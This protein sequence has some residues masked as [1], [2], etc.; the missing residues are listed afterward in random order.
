MR[1]L[2]TRGREDALRTADKLTN[3]GHQII[4]SPV[5]DICPTGAAWPQGLADAVVA[6]SGAA[7]D[8]A[9][10]PADYPLPEARRLMRLFV[11]GT[12]TAEAARRGGFTGETVVASD[13]KELATK[14]TSLLTPQMRLIYLAGHDRKPDL[15]TACRDAG[16]TIIPIETYEARAATQ[17]SDD[18]FS[19]F[20]NDGIDI[21]LHYS[22]RSAEIFLSLA[23][24]A[25]INLAAVQHVAISPDAAEPLHDAA[26]Q[27]VAIA[28]EPK[29]VAILALLS[30]LSSPKRQEAIE[31]IRAAAELLKGLSA[32][33]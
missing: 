20:H 23:A 6:T 1:I 15:E 31:N 32:H 16:L 7:F 27:R 28:A 19:A 9:E 10:F 30:E 3:S 29:E 13:S 2:L 8:F 14:L 26:C 18:A 12:K 22:R 4:L 11:V 5:I 25:G 24:S 33:P 17:L 21:V